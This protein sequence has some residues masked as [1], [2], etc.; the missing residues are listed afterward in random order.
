M[1]HSDDDC[2]LGGQL[3]GH[4]DVHL[5]VCRILAEAGHLD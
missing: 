1:T 3:V 2:W 5:Y 4:I